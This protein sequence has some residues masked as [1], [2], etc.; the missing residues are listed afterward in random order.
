MV[1][2]FIVFLGH[3][4]PDRRRGFKKAVKKYVFLSE[5]TGRVNQGKSQ[6]DREKEE[7]SQEMEDEKGC[8]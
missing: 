5:S 1:C 6:T 3:Q 7:K 2:R 8:D 4:R